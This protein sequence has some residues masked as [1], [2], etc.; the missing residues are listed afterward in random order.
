MT[1]SLI[2]RLTD[3]ASL[4]PLIAA[5]LTRVSRAKGG[6]RERSP[7]QQLDAAR[8]VTEID[9]HPVLLTEDAV[10]EERQSASRFATKARKR[11]AALLDDIRA[12]RYGVVIVWE[13]D[14]AARELEAWAAFLNACRDRGVLIHVI[15]HRRTYDVRVGRDWRALADDGVDAAY[16]SEKLSVNIRRGHADSAA[17]G[18]P[19]GRAPYGYRRV[20]DGR[21][22]LARVDGVWQQIPDDNAPVVREII[23][24]IA[25]QVPLNEVQRDLAARGVVLPRSTVRAIALNPA[26]AALRP[27]PGGHAQGSWVPIVAEATWR[28]AVAVIDD[29]RDTRPGST[30]WLLSQVGDCACGASRS[31]KGKQGKGN[32]AATYFCSACGSKVNAA[33]ADEHVMALALGRLARPDAAAVFARDTSAEAAAARV[34]LGRLK[35]KLARHRDKLEAATNASDEAEQEEQIRRLK[36]KIAA[37]QKRAEELST[38][39]A[40][41]AFADALGN[42][43]AV[44]ERWAAASLPGRKA[45]LRVVFERIELG[46]AAHRGQP[47]KERITHRWAENLTVTTA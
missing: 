22:K 33:Q 3:R 31:W 7:E 45:V 20:Y 37:A 8:Q 1:T 35:D 10:Y 5:V 28:Q 29:H 39:P 46:R 4:V 17:Q 24:R 42:A 12:G 14:R 11:F 19:P 2:D 25:A 43:Q 27:V 6:D 9:G 32:S 16:F 23:E 13:A 41:A 44:A 47:A 34:E 21:G 18:R 26:Y 38:P 30:V 36:P 15:T 40:L